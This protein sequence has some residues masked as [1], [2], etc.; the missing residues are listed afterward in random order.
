MKFDD[1][2]HTPVYMPS[3]IHVLIT[4]ESSRVP[5]A[6]HP[7]SPHAP[8]SAELLI[9]ILIDCLCLSLDI[10]NGLIQCNHEVGTLC[11]SFHAT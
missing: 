1:C 3:E 6:A 8:R 7:P 4:P 11:V 10:I 9:I 2:I 5:F